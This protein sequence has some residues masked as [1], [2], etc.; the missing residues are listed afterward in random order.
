M[1]SI[2]LNLTKLTHVRKMFKDSEGKETECLVIPIDKNNLQRSTKEGYNN[3]YLD[4]AA[5]ELKEPRKNDSGNL[6]QTHLIKRSMSKE[7][8]ENMSEEE[9]NN[10]PILGNLVDFD[11]YNSKQDDKP[12]DAAGGEVIDSETD[13]LP[14]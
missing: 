5:F 9:R 4:L 3:V 11:K 8:R 6:S 14:F 1:I 13:D 2:K 10:Q 7:E 12:N